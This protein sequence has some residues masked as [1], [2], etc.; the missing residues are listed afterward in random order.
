MFVERRQ[1]DYWIDFGDEAAPRSL[2][3]R[4][5]W[6]EGRRQRVVAS[7][8]LELYLMAAAEIIP[9]N[10]KS[11]R[12]I[13]ACWQDDFG[14]ADE[15]TQAAH[16]APR[17]LI[18]RSRQAH[19]LLRIPLPDRSDYVQGFFAKTDTLPANYNKS[20]SRCERN[21]LV[22]GFEAACK[23]AISS[24]HI[25]EMKLKAVSVATKTA[26]DVYRMHARNSFQYCTQRLADKI[27][28]PKPLP[29]NEKK[30]REQLLITDGYAQELRYS[31]AIST[32]TRLGEMEELVKTYRKL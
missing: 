22:K 6:H 5:R 24:G 10:T 25:G 15:Q 17:Q 16:C 13:K 29:H 28:F 7:I 23:I 9:K 19:D 18:I 26:F 3:D 11:I 27:K 32:I 4:A 30:W 14:S 1:S 2:K 8:L 31:T 20:D 21:G 12:L